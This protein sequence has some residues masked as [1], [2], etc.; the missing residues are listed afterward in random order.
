LRRVR[1]R[2]III[3]VLYIPRGTHTHI[4]SHIQ[5]NFQ[6]I[7]THTHTAPSIYE[8]RVHAQLT[9]TRE[10]QRIHTHINYIHK[11][12]VKLDIRVPYIYIFQLRRGVVFYTFA[13]MCAGYAFICEYVLN[14][15]WQALT[16][17]YTTIMFDEC[18]QCC[19]CINFFLFFRIICVSFWLHVLFICTN[20]L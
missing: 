4:R 2:A 10:S 11:I 8:M 19:I 5:I 13:F 14:G 1:R 9:Y 20:K 18:V 12:H 16:F 7:S 17:V 3:Y 15:I 6:S